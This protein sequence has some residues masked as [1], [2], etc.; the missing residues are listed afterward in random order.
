M[1]NK[2]KY[3]K[4]ISVKLART[5]VIHFYLSLKSIFVINFSSDVHFECAFLFFKSF[6][7]KMLSFL[8]VKHFLFQCSL[9]IILNILFIIYFFEKKLKDEIQVKILFSENCQAV[10][11]PAYFFNVCQFLL[12]MSELTKSFE[13]AS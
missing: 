6:I 9:K 12:I 8:F 1:K 10:F 2:Q 11:I 3:N 13:I 4:A 5:Y 7:F